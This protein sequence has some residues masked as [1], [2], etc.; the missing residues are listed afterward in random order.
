MT[1]D[2]DAPA[3]A[4]QARARGTALTAAPAANRLDDGHGMDDEV[5]RALRG[6]LPARPQDTRIDWV[7]ALEELA[8]VSPALAVV[9]GADVLGLP[10][11]GASHWPGCRG[12]DLDALRPAGADDLWHLAL[13]AV[14]VGG[15]RAAVDAA[16]A[17]LREAK[18]DG[19][20]ND[21]AQPGVADA[22][23]AVDAS[24]LLLWDAAQQPPGERE[25]TARQLARLHALDSVATAMMALL[26]AVGPDACR[27]G[28]DLDRLRR[29]LDSLALVLG[30]APTARELAAS[31][32]SG[33]AL[34]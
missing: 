34:D 30:D 8:A 26:P 11:I 17:A 15:A 18:A 10:A 22:A 2:L 23:T 31:T 5:R 25:A 16:V 1:F 12:I 20:P 6:V 7:V 19:H 3:A 33:A 14:F 24:R 4:R 27:S 21:A 29:D 28:T 32:T 9:G 13:T